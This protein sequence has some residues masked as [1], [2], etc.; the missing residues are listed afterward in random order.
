M[1]DVDRTDRVLRV[2]VVVVLGNATSAAA[3]RRRKAGAKRAEL[4]PLVV[5]H[6]APRVVE[7][8][9]PDARRALVQLEDQRMILAPSALGRLELRDVVELREAP[10][11]LSRQN[12]GA[13]AK[14]SCSRHTEERIWH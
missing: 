9:A 6:V 11:Q 12:R 1:R 14:L 10:Q 7:L 8:P 4:A 5:H 2:E 3:G 13:R